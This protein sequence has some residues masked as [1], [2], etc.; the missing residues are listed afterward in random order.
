MILLFVLVKE[1]RL[2]FDLTPVVSS[3]SMALPVIVYVT[4]GVRIFPLPLADAENFPRYLRGIVAVPNTGIGLPGLG[5]L[6]VR[7][8]S[9]SY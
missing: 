3:R 6:N 9:T 5:G 2:V 1:I 8:K 7:I 4:L